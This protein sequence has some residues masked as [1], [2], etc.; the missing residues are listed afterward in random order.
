MDPD[1]PSP[2]NRSSSEIIHWILPNLTSSQS[3]PYELTNTSAAFVEWQPPAPGAGSGPHRYTFLLFEQPDSFSYPSEYAGYGGRNRTKFNAESF[4][5][6]S[7][8]GRLVAADYVVT[9]NVTATNSTGGSGN[10]TS[11]TNGTVTGGQPSPTPFKGRAPA[12]S[13]PAWALVGLYTATIMGRV[14]L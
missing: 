7:G 8:L 5:Q 6:A 9:E 10:A 4:V 1:A 12:L 2:R 11:G 14:A 13:A 3:R